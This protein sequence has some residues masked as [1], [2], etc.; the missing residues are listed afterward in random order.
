MATGAVNTYSN[1]EPLGF[2]G[3]GFDATADATPTLNNLKIAN[4]VIACAKGPGDSPCQVIVFN[5]SFLTGDSIV[6]GNN[7]YT[8]TNNVCPIVTSSPKFDTSYGGFIYGGW[9][10]NNAGVCEIYGS[11]APSRQPST[12]PSVSAAP[13][14]QPSSQPSTA[15]SVSAAPSTAPS[16]SGKKSRKCS[17]TKTRP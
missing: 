14:S 9:D 2:R 11:A 10:N 16:K 1:W 3:L 4:N 17:K 6:A 15:P 8:N 12:A 13:S 7:Y 5:K